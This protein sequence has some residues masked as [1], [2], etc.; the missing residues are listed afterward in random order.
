MLVPRAAEFS[1]PLMLYKAVKL[2]ALTSRDGEVFSIFVG[3]NEEI[4]Q[5]VKKQSLSDTEIQANTSDRVRFGEGKYEEWYSKNRTP[6]ALVHDATGQLAAFVWFGQ[7][8]L[9]RQS[10]KY[11]SEEERAKELEQKED[12]WH[13]LVYRSYPPFRGQGLMGDFVRFCME[14]Y[15]KH[16]P[17]A[18]LWTGMSASNEA[19]IA[20]SS[21]LGFVRHDD[22][23]D[24]E[25]NWVAM[26]LE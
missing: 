10:L 18:K 22:L 26:T 2:G 6:F 8:P 21:K 24:A 14:V 23:F 20:L 5:Q 13:T 12:V 16:Y 7:K 25:K 19:S 3:A 1:L 9:G 17:D 4:V 15:R 11:L